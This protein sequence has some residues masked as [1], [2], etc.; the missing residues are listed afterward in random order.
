MARNFSIGPKGPFNGTNPN[1]VSVQGAAVFLANQSNPAV[2]VYNSGSKTVFL[3][4]QDPVSNPSAGQP[5]SAGSS[6]GWDS[7]QALY[8]ITA[9]GETTTI[10]VTNNSGNI[11]DAGAIATQIIDQGL[12]QDIANA[13]SITGAP[14]IDQFTNIL[15]QTFTGAAG[16]LTPSAVDVSMYQSLAI[17]YSQGSIPQQGA[18]LVIWTDASFNTLAQEKVVF[19]SGQNAA[20][21]IGHVLELP[22]RGSRV[23]I[24]LLPVLGTG[25]GFVINVSG[26]YKTLSRSRFNSVGA[27]SADGSII[28]AGGAVEGYHS[29]NGTIPVSTTWSWQP[30]V[31]GGP[32]RLS[33]RFGAATTFSLTVRNPAQ[34]LAILESENASTTVVNEIRHYDFYLPPQP[35]EI[36]LTSGAGSTVVFR[37]T[38]VPANPYAN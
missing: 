32:V 33:L 5:L 24:Q 13:I 25:T 9:A 1:A 29:W 8:A 31:V 10:T 11:F 23:A 20:G 12:A 15:R 21:N 16:F 3:D 36:V 4:S 6:I 37:A 38:L 18:L 26:S 22:V 28:P 14:P 27:G 2:T 19:G 35:C 17:T 7:K 30:D 34:P